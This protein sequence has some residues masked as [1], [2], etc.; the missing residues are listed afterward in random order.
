MK[1]CQSFFK[2][3]TYPTIDIKDDVSEIELFEMIQSLELYGEDDPKDYI[4]T[5]KF[6]PYLHEKQVNSQIFRQIDTILSVK[7]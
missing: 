4:L 1:K 5:H 6:A 2:L 3:G 7:F